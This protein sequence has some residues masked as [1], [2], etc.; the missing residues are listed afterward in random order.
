M[1]SFVC[2]KNPKHVEVSGGKQNAD[3]ELSCY[4]AAKSLSQVGYKCSV[5]A[6]NSF[7]GLV[8]ACKNSKYVFIQAVWVTTSDFKELRKIYPNTKFIVQIRSNTPFLANESSVY[9]YLKEI[10]REGALIAFNDIRSNVFDFPAIYL[11]NMYYGQKVDIKRKVPDLFL[12][13][14]CFGAIR[15]MKNHFTQAL[16]AI[17]YAES[18]NKT[19]RFHVNFTRIEHGNNIAGNLEDLFLDKKHQL[20][21]VPWLTHIELLNY[22]NNLDMSMQV[23]LTESFNYVAADSVYMKVPFVGS[24]EIKFI[25][26]W[27]PD[28]GSAEDIAKYL[29][30]HSNN[31]HI[32]KY[33]FNQLSIFHADAVN[34]WKSFLK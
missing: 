20:V 11:P 7:E 34:R 10:S 25:Y 3:L 5:S 15:P 28:P 23:S 2:Y 32:I 12:D 17:K 4:H 13:V 31:E 22:M 18:I 1:I 30:V 16:A 9:K 33:N 14:G 8:E 27:H 21:K 24:S 19:L 26:K 6:V 29:S